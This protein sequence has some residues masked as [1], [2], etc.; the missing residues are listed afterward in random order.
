MLSGVNKS[1]ENYTKLTTRI[2]SGARDKQPIFI[3][4]LVRLSIVKG[5]IFCVLDKP[6]KAVNEFK[7]ANEVINLIICGH[8]KIVTF[9]ENPD[10]RLDTYHYPVEILQ[11]KYYLQ[12]G[13]WAKRFNPGAALGLF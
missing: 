10:L 13:F 4:L 11:Q 5:H 2:D 9:A 6:V 12:L 3:D 8:F 7:R 1:I